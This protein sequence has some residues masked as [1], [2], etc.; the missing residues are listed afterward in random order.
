[1]NVYKL[2]SDDLI[3]LDKVERAICYTEKDGYG[4]IYGY[5]LK[6]IFDSGKDLTYKY[7]EKKERNAEYER[8]CEQLRGQ[9]S[10]L[11]YKEECSEGDKKIADRIYRALLGTEHIKELEQKD[12]C[13]CWV[14]KWR[15]EDL[16][17]VFKEFGVEVG[18]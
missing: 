15:L 2:S 8:I 5:M 18:E 1:M 7:N 4:G 6:I 17:R 3:V 12:N 11:E 9:E 13:E 14:S 10:V 16:N